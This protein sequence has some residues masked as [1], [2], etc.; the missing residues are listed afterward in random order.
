MLEHLG[1]RIR[2][3][4]REKGMTLTE[5]ADK[6]GIA[7]AT[8]SRIETG[9]MIGTVESHAKIAEM[10]GVPLSELYA[11]T[12]AAAAQAAHLSKSKRP[13]HHHKNAQVE[14]LTPESGS[15]KISAVLVTLQA[16]AETPA[17]QSPR[18]TGKLIYV[19][20]GEACVRIGQEDYIIKAGESLTFE[21]DCQHQL[22]NL[23]SLPA[24]ILSAAS[25]ASRP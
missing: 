4:R 3:L 20:E 13:V 18:G 22:K 25:P 11:E 1:P 24:K 9:T 17:E 21:A 19:L 12:G 6:T 2:Q 14:L 16:G 8:L 15:R 7:Q 10:L 23:S 5:I